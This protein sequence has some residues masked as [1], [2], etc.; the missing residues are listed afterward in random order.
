MQK[1]IHGVD[2]EFLLYSIHTIH[3]LALRQG[4]S[5]LLATNS[6]TGVLS[7]YLPLDRLDL[8]QLCTATR[9]DLPG[10]PFKLV[11]NGDVVVDSTGLYAAPEGTQVITFPPDGQNVSQLLNLQNWLR[12]LRPW[13]ARRVLIYHPP[14]RLQT[15][16]AIRFLVVTL[17]QQMEW[18]SRK[19]D[20]AVVLNDGRQAS[21]HLKFERAACYRKLDR[22]SVDRLMSALAVYGRVP[23]PHSRQSRSETET[24][25][26]STA[27]DSRSPAPRRSMPVRELD[28][29]KQGVLAKIT[30]DAPWKLF[31]GAD[32]DFVATFRGHLARLQNRFRRNTGEVGGGSRF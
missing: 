4:S 26:D 2:V 32:H 15:A 5:T 12:H 21:F 31:V 20:M 3:S 10:A 24:D 14:G 30:S 11:S 17:V 9:K 1:T 8:L 6:N 23:A 28:A 18:T 27:A 22:R 7:F 19:A 13:R 25:R 29:G 16:H